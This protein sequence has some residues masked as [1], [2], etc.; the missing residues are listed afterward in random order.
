MKL[1]YLLCS[2]IGDL[3]CLTNANVGTLASSPAVLPGVLV[4]VPMMCGNRSAL[5]EAVK[6]L[7]QKIYRPD[8]SH[9]GLYRARDDVA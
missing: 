8:M 2:P 9:E 6:C 7:T 5:S 4:P 1:H 3:V